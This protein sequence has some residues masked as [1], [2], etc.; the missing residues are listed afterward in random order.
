MDIAVGG[1]ASQP[2]TVDPSSSAAGQGSEIRTFVE[3]YASQP[4][5]V[6]SDSSAAAE[7]GSGMG[8]FAES[9]ASQPRIVAYGGLATAGQ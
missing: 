6:A 5:A 2:D 7:Q 9:R 3:S 8:T 1:R 4:H